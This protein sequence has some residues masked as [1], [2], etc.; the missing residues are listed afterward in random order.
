MHVVL[1]NPP[2]ISPARADLLPLGLGYIGTVAQQAGHHV[3]ILDVAALVTYA[4]QHGSLGD[5]FV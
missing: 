3:T 5:I 2:R 4:F 1:V